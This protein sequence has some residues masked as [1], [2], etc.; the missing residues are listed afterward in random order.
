MWRAQGAFPD[1][2]MRSGSWHRMCGGYP[3]ATML[4][5]RSQRSAR[6]GIYVVTGIGN[7]AETANIPL[8]DLTLSQK[9]IQGSLYGQCNP[10]RDIPRQLELYLSGKLKLDELITARY[11][12]D[13]VPRRGT[14]I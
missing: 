1:R 9:R 5:R 7:F 6:P 8:M 13:Q 2:Q 14:R 10:S 4:L 11:T 12:L 3:P